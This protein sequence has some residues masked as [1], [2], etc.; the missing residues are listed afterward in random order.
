[1]TQTVFF[2]F[3]K[4]THTAFS[5]RAPWLA[6]NT[7]SPLS[8]EPQISAI[9]PVGFHMGPKPSP[10]PSCTEIKL[11]HL[12]PRV[13][14]D[15]APQ[16]S[17]VLIACSQFLKCT[18][19]SSIRS[20]CCGTC[21]LSAWTALPLHSLLVSSLKGYLLLRPPLESLSIDLRQRCS[22]VVPGISQS[23]CYSVMVWLQHPPPMADSVCL[24]PL[25]PNNV[26]PNPHLPIPVSTLL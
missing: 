15:L 18:G 17:T 20:A 11:C 25:V 21:G 2:L 24:S 3:S 5:G 12:A 10:P 14:H 6:Q 16:S 9:F 8:S 7:C 22:S 1:M 4:C 13:Q 26:L 19:H 23:L